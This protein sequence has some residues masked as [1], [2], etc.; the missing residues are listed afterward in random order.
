MGTGRLCSVYLCMPST[1]S[2][3]PPVR[4]GQNQGNGATVLGVPL[5][6]KYPQR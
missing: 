3:E 5:H 1:R 2:G 4:S 6:A